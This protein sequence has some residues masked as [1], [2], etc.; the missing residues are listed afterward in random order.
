MKK[1]SSIPVS[2]NREQ[3]AAIAAPFDLERLH[4]QTPA[5]DIEREPA[6]GDAVS[7]YFAFYGID[8]E[9]R[10]PGLKHH[11]G[12]FSSGSYE[13]VAHYF[14]LAEPQ[15]TC[16]VFHGY[17][18]HSGLFRHVIE[19]CL[20][21]QLN[22]VIYDLP[23]HGLST[24]ERASI[25][26]FKDYGVVLRDCLK[27]FS[28]KAPQP[29]HAIAQST[30]GA[31]MMDYLLRGAAGAKVPDFSKVVLLGPLL[32]AAEWRWVKTA[33]W[34]GHKFLERVNRRFAVNSG[35]KTF[36]NFLE[37]IDP[38]QDRYISVRWVEALLR[39]E[40]LF[41]SFPVSNRRLL[42]VQGQRDT[43]VDWRYNIPVIREKFPQA[44]YL[45]LQDAYH[46][47]AN[48]TPEVREKIFAAI[49]LYMSV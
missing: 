43:T 17:F 22:V 11:F 47:L 29:W 12:H 24:G 41:A 1:V 9:Q 18:D 2:N 14:S 28:A 33:Y 27:L 15:G 10:F 30:G 34:L 5:F 31:V 7:A 23:G 38:L 32:R 21:R 39:W 37:K 36:L 49:D 4:Q 40:R 45:P 19:Y 6:N 13:I 3:G 16:F 44:K 35:D 26:S 46:H 20:R 8:F 25:P 48:E 42:I